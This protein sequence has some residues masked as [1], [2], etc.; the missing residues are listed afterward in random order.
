MV[1]Q[2]PFLKVSVDCGVPLVA[3]VSGHV[4]RALDLAPG[5]GVT[6]VLRPADLYVIPG[7]VSRTG[8]G[9]RTVPSNR[10]R[11]GAPSLEDL[12]AGGPEQ[13]PEHR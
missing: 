5:C 8:I 1:T 6:V 11:R 13:P 10:S 2:G 4:A 9:S 7:G 3:A 12:N